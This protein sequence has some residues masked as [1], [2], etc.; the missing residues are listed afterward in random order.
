[1]RDPMTT[2]YY[3]IIATNEDLARTIDDSNRKRVLRRLRQV[4]K[5]LG[6]RSL[7]VGCGAEHAH[8]LIEPSWDH[9]LENFTGEVENAF[10][11]VRGRLPEGVDLDGDCYFFPVRAPHLRAEIRAIKRQRR[12]HREEGFVTEIE[13]MFAVALRRGTS[14]QVMSRLPPEACYGRPLTE[15]EKAL[16][17]ARRCIPDWSPSSE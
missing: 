15:E 4:A 10:R 13:R 5:L 9:D 8:L 6:V 2:R 17:K 16:E 3:H 1:M 11:A 14:Y 12:R 7:A